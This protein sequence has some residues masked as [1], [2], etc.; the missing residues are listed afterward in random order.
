MLS[1]YLLVM[2][3]LLGYLAEQ[4]N[5]CALKA[6][7]TGTLPGERKRVDGHDRQISV[8]KDVDVCG[9]ATIVASG[10]A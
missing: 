9:L 5:I 1:I 10:V 8:L 6:V 4:R 7:I 2:G 3:L